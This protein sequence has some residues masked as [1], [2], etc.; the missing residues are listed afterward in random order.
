MTVLIA[1]WPEAVQVSVLILMLHCSRAEQSTARRRRY[2]SV[3]V[4]SCAQKNRLNVNP[5]IPVRSVVVV[6]T[7]R[8]RRS[9]KN[10]TCMFVCSH[11]DDV[12]H[13]WMRIA[14][15]LASPG[16]EMNLGVRKIMPL[17]QF[18]PTLCICIGQFGFP[19]SFHR[20]LLFMTINRN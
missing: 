13:K 15:D 1:L 19:P 17:P 18:R 4:S 16:R 6:S 20:R 12:Q 7:E 2:S 3:T 9:R 8:R 14:A 10:C 11:A 5:E